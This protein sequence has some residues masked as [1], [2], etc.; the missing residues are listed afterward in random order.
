MDRYEVPQEEEPEKDEFV[1]FWAPPPFVPRMVEAEL[2][3]GTRLHPAQQSDGR[4]LGFDRRLPRGTRIRLRG[5]VAWIVG[6]GP[7]SRQ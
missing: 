6:E 7:S 2:P 3:D 4:R 1:V 5:Q